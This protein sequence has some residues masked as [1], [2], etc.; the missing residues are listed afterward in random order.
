MKRLLRVI[1]LFILTTLITGLLL[2]FW[3]LKGMARCKRAQM[4]ELLNLKQKLK[5]NIK[6]FSY[7]LKWR[8]QREKQ[9]RAKS[10]THSSYSF[11]I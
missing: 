9:S 10:T 1:V 7:N 2:K 5:E 3:V 6:N 11:R 8:Q 4:S